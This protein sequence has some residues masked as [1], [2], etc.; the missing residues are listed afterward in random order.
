ML[1]YAM[2]KDAA[3]EGV[4]AGGAAIGGAAADTIK[5]TDT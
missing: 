4:S 1:H 5:C 3:E 2:R